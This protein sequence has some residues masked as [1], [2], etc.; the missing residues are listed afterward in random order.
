MYSTF[1]PPISFGNNATVL[2]SGMPSEAA[3]P[4]AETVTPIFT[5]AKTGLL[6]A[7]EKLM[8]TAATAI[9]TVLPRKANFIDLRPV[10]QFS[11][12]RIACEY[13]ADS[14]PS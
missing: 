6:N 4:V 1:C 8:E 11:A 2:F 5:S 10:N 7:A 9:A 12:W 14:R 13:A 3:G